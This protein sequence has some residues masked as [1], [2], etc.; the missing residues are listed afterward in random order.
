MT[1]RALTLLA[2]AALIAGCGDESPPASDP[3]VNAGGNGSGDS[4]VP[5]S[6]CSQ[7]CEHVVKNGA[8]CTD[9]DIGGRCVANCS[10]YA[11][12]ACAPE[13]V[14]FR[15]CVMQSPGLSCLENGTGPLIL[16]T[17]GCQAENKAWAAC[18]EEKDAGICY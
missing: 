10:K 14:A 13:W 8:G 5:A 7:Y 11:A 6:S 3:L 15:A 16:A 9:F 12:G 4:G 18:L 17:Q 2:C 1:H